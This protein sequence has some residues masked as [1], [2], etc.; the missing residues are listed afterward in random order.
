M[1]CFQVAEFESDEDDDFLGCCYSKLLPLLRAKGRDARVD[2]G[3][4]KLR[5]TISGEINVALFVDSNVP[6]HLAQE[7]PVH[8]EASDE[9][10]QEHLTRQNS[11]LSTDLL[12][13]DD[14]E[15]TIE[16]HG[17]W[18]EDGKFFFGV[19]VIAGR[20]M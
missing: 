4:I 3:W 1:K 20:N 14:V 11:L 16:D 17:G 13:R 10:H 9:S 6:N 19:H 15:D 12:T 7:T 8:N 2:L 5:N 18:R